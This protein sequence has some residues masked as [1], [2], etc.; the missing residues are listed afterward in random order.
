[1][2]S[3]YD[4]GFDIG[5]TQIK[6]GL[7]DRDGRLVRR[8][9]VRS[10]ETMDDILAVLEEAWASLE[11]NAPGPI[12]SCGFGIAGF[13]SRKERRILQSPNYP[14]LNG[15][16]LIPALRKFIDVPVR[17]NNDANMAAFGE[18]VH[19]AGRG[20]RS[21]VL[22][23]I[24]TG[25]GSGIIL[26]GKLWEGEG[27][28]AGEIGHITVNP[29][30]EPCNCGGRGC[31]ETEASAPRMVKNYQALI[32]TDG[33]HGLPRG[34]PPGQGRRPGR[35]RELPDHAPIGWASAWASSSTCSIPRRSS[36]AAGSSRP[37]SS[38]SA[39]PSRRPGRGPI[40]SRSP[41]AA[42]NGPP[43]A[44]TPASWAR[45]PGPVSRRGRGH[46]GSI[47]GPGGW[48]VPAIPGVKVFDNPGRKNYKMTAVRETKEAALTRRFPAALALGAALL[49]A[50]AL[51]SFASGPLGAIKGRIVDDKGAPILGGLPLRGLPGGAG[52]GQFHHLRVGPLQ[53]HRPHA[54][55]LQGRRRGARVQDRQRRRGGPVPGF[56]GHARFQDG[57]D[58]HRGGD[59]H[60]SGRVR[61]STAIRRGR[62][63][64]STRT[65]SRACP[66]PATSRP[67]W[68]SSPGSSS[69]STPPD[70]RRPSRGPR[71]AANVLIQDSVNVTNPIG[72]G[73]MG[74]INIDLIDEVVVETAG[75]AAEGGTGPGRYDQR[76][77]PPGLG[78]PRNGASPTASRA[79]G[80]PIRSGPTESSPRCPAPRRQ[81]SGE[82]TICRSPSAGPFSRRWPGSTAT[83]ASRPRAAGLRTATGPIPSASAISSTITPRGTSRGMFK[84]SMSV[85]EKFKGALEFGWSG[86]R[87]PVYE[88][89]ITPLRPETSTRELDNERLFLARGGGVV[90]R[91]PDDEGRSVHRVREAQQAACS[92]ELAGDRQARILRRHHRTELGERTAE[93][94]RGPSRMRVGASVTRF[95]DGFLGCP[96]DLSLGGD[97][98]DDDGRLVDLEG[99]QSH[100]LLCRRE[101]LHVRPDDL[102]VL[103]RR[104]RLGARRVL[105]RPRGGGGPVAPARAQEDRR[106]RPGY[107]EAL[108]AAV[109]HRGPP[110][111][112][113]GGPARDRQ[114]GPRAATPQRP[115]RRLPHRPPHG[116]QPLQRDDPSRRGTR[117][118]SGT[119]YLRAS[120]SSST[121]SAAARRSSR[122]PGRGS[123]NTWASATP[124]TWPRSIPGPP[125]RSFGS[126]RTRTARS[127]RSTA[128]PSSPTISG[129]TRPNSTASP[130]TRISR[131]PS[132]RNGRPA[133]SS[134]SPAISLSRPATSSAATPTTSG[135]PSSTRPPGSP[136]PGSR[137]PRKAG[138]SPSRPSCPEGA[139][140]TTSR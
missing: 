105:H 67:S 95:L 91:Q 38:Y 72:A 46:E 82:S 109:P 61:P 132:S 56:H 86:V 8:G 124:R 12:R 80:W 92:A 31:L 69:I 50:L 36:S 70:C 11:K 37:E 68:G 87:E 16:P 58:R 138:G 76:P 39:R 21:L 102:A 140:T 1:M 52:P 2:T 6:Y 51:P 117:P 126:T 106:L 59:R 43:W 119:R 19:G 18:F 45:P 32:G 123:R 44:T 115:A 35:P 4:A 5:G 125:M 110:L 89:D 84:L 134:S 112:P 73:E 100:P 97:Y 42:S 94:P 22:L 79:R 49:L 127:A 113:L 75:H 71:R 96:H 135:T 83:C 116:V 101:P 120:G 118:S 17:I 15:Y 28:Y 136:G 88:E 53:H 108:R 78:V 121:S 41:A 13:Y 139:I 20:A 90:Y 81:P 9:Q 60:P 74:R 133:W 129:S 85:V 27:G 64:I 103:R 25:I 47:R 54:G 10:P 40:G 111:R 7:V 33:R 122:R 130:S 26:D 55:H 77:P 29:E 131:P 137:T 93:R 128:S 24:G 99:Q 30:G 114:Q 65:S 34:L 3:S 48:N 63:S 98:E 57:A 66:W 104:G 62:R 14:C 107:H 23:T